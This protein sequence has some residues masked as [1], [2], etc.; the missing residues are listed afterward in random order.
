MGEKGKD[1][2]PEQFCSSAKKDGIRRINLEK[3]VTYG[4]SKLQASQ[5]RKKKP[6]LLSSIK[7]HFKHLNDTSFHYPPEC[8]PLAQ[9]CQLGLS[10]S[11]S[12][13]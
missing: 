13:G 2:L 8:R 7:E 1:S 12:I 5:S 4:I 3:P 9:S 6:S 10:H 11:A